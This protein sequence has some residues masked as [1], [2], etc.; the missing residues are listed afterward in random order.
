MKKQDLLNA[1]ENVKLNDISEKRIMDKVMNY[2]KK[3]YGTMSKKKICLIAAA[4]VLVMGFSVYAGSGIVSSWHSGSSSKPDYKQLPTEEQCIEDIGY[5]PVLIEEFENG[6]EFSGGHI[7]SNSLNDDN[8]N[9]IEK[10]KSISAEYSKDDDE[11]IL[12]AMKYETKQPQ[13]GDIIGS[14]NGCDL[15]YINYTNKFVPPGYEMTEEDKKAQETGEIVFSV[16]SNEVN[17]SEVQGLSWEVDGIHYNLTQIDGDLDK[18][19]LVE[20]AEEIIEK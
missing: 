15:Y 19:G 12:S 20:M 4:A 11:V 2:E 17:I 8:N 3:E 9:A 1:M 16:G 13:E 18:D 10:F 14:F 6:Y 7:V 5:A